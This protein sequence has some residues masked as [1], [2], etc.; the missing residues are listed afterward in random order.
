MAVSTFGVARKVDQVTSRYSRTATGIFPE[1]CAGHHIG[2]NHG[3][4]PEGTCFT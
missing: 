3:G 4:L 2:D 1:T